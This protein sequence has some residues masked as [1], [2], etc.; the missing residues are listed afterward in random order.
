MGEKQILFKNRVESTKALVDTLPISK[1]KDEDWIVIATSANGV[2]IANDISK[3]INSEF[4]FMFSEKLFAPL[5]HECEIAIVT[6][7]Q[8]VIIH[9]ELV[10]TFN[11][12]LDFIYAQAE[13]LY[14]VT[15]LSYI[16]QYRDGDNIKDLKNQN[17][18][19]IDEGLNTGLT[20]MACIKTA[21]SLGAKS[22]SVAVPIIPKATVGDI[23]SI[24][25]DLYCPN[26]L[27]HFVAID[28]YYDQLDEI[29]FDKVKKILQKD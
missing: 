6:E 14:Q 13:I 19:L 22:V 26:I 15:I 7:N 10:R 21:I 12:D 18:L 25:D 24:A 5:N 28:F 8:D 11:I 9:E 17:V 4:D 23:E 16:A 27:E 29:S 2:P 20:M 3:L 1:M